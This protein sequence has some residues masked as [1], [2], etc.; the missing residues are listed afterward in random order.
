LRGEPPGGRAA[1]PRPAPPPA[2][3]HVQSK[4]VCALTHEVMDADNPPLVLPNGMVYSTRAVDLISRRNNG[5]MVCPATE[6]VFPAS[7]AKRLFIL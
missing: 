7:D 2:P 5:K 3:Q 4:L 6:S 1:S